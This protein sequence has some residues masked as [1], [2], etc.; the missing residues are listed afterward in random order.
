MI[1]LGLCCL[2]REEPIRYRTTTVAYAGRLKERGE[3]FK[4]FISLLVKNNLQALEATLL[5]CA[6]HGIGSF[7]INSEFLPLF[8]HPI[9]SYRLEELH[10]GQ[11][12][13]AQFAQCKSLAE[14]AHI[15]F[16]FHPDH[17]VVINSPREEVVKNSLAELEY[18]GELAERL[19]ADVINI[20]AG[21]AHGDKK[22]ALER[23][24]EG[25]KRLS[26]KV[27]TRLTVE[28]DDRAYTPE[29][30]LPLCHKIQ[31]PLVYDVHHHRCLPDRHSLEETTQLAYATWNREPL[32]HL[33]SPKEGWKGAQPERHHD[34][35]DPEDFPAYW[36]E[37]PRLTVDI[38]AK[39]K[40][41][42]V[43]QLQRVFAQKLKES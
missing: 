37:L 31:I 34:Y 9:H 16:T 40:E 26:P 35:I 43:L 38:E 28:N 24:V 18:H 7:R 27:Q 4:A 19:G 14:Q 10:E 5:Y 42:A 23:F 41:L 8:T 32:F 22:A 15:R 12:I 6:S 29:D 3:D 33:S 25:F 13:L 17:F 2:F 20:H 21:G 36:W 11:A 30:L 39:G 1:R